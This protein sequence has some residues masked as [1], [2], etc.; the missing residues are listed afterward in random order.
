MSRTN[1]VAKKLSLTTETLR[2]LDDKSIDSVA[3]GSESDTAG[4][5]VLETYVC[6]KALPRP[7]GPF[8]T[9]NACP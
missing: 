9:S 5:Y 3:G 4:G 1:Q 6:P 7:S 8:T 2:V